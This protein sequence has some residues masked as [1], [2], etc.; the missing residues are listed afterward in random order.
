MK[1]TMI[2]AAAAAVLTAAALAGCTTQPDHTG[3][4]ASQTPEYR[5]IPSTTDR[6]PDPQTTAQAQ[7][8]SVSAQD[9]PLSQL[10]A[11][12]DSDLRDGGYTDATRAAGALPPAVGD[13]ASAISTR[14]TPS[15]ATDEA[16]RLASLWSGVTATAA[17]AGADLTPAVTAYFTEATTLCM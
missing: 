15:L 10:W 16:A 1:R 5:S 8:A 13:F 14:C 12:V 6:A 7:G 17:D 9:A 3:Q 2:V 4:A 11:M